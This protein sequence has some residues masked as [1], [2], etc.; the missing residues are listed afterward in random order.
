LPILQMYLALLSVTGLVLA[1]M[2]TERRRAEQDARESERRYRTLLENAPEAVLVHQD[3]RW[4][5][6][7]RV[8][9][10]LLHAERAE[11]LLDHATLD[12]VH[13]G[14]RAACASGRRTTAGPSPA[15]CTRRSA[16]A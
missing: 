4:I 9:L 11:Q 5:F 14:Y 8:A 16:R 10:K 3:G 12:I 2:T 15:S 6:A 13:P 1:A 7:N